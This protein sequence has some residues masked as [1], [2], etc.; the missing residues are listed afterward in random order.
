MILRIFKAMIDYSFIIGIPDKVKC[1]IDRQRYYTD[2][3]IKENVQRIVAY[4]F[5]NNKLMPK[6]SLK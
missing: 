6:Y 2:R 4:C 3:K 5:G 1:K